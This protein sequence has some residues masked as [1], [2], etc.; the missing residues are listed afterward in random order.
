[1]NVVR[2]AIPV[3]SM[4]RQLLGNGWKFTGVEGEGN[5]EGHSTT[6]IKDRVHPVTCHEGA[7]GE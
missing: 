4:A 2:V 6:S 3:K 7:E 1:V 5:M